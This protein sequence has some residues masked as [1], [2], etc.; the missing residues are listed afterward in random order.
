MLSLEAGMMSELPD[1]TINIDTSQMRHVKQH[2]SPIGT[3]QSNEA[4]LP[5]MA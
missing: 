3:L 2:C 5:V 1:K 4:T